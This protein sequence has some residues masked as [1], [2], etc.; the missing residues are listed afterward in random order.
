MTLLITPVWA[1][2]CGMPRPCGNVIRS[3]VVFIGTTIAGGDG[4]KAASARFKVLKAFKGVQPGT[5]QDVD[6]ASQTSCA[7]VFQVGKDYLVFADKNG[8]RLSTTACKGSRLLSSAVDE[9]RYL[10]SWREGR[11]PTEIVGAV[12]PNARGGD[13]DWARYYRAMEAA[14]IRVIGPDGKSTVAHV[15]NQGNFAA[16]V[17]SPG[18]YCV[19][20]GVAQVDQRSP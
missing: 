17:P 9:V 19:S 15:D 2:S 16:A 6:T 18:K 3:G 4:W 20:V 5:V 7:A 14:L 10:E 13:A 8:G 1:C 11:T 12:F